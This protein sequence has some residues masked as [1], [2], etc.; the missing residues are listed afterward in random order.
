MLIEKQENCVSHQV[1]PRDIVRGFFMFEN[2]LERHKTSMLVLMLV[3]NNLVNSKQESTKK[4]LDSFLASKDKKFC[5]RPNYVISEK[6]EKSYLMI[7]YTLDNVSIHFVIEMKCY[8]SLYL[9]IPLNICFEYMLYNKGGRTKPYH[10]LLLVL[11][12]RE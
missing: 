4:R 8:F 3:K 7:T 9:C 10:F 1:K 5:R 6:I 11:I 2:L 12:S